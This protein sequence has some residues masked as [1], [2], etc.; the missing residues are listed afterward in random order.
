MRD[1]KRVIE[2]KEGRNW[3][4]HRV[5]TDEKEIYESL[6]HDLIAKKISACTWIK[7]IKRTQNYDG[8]ITITVLY[9]NNCRSLYTV[10]SDN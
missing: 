10:K 6:A 7:S 3:N 2:V 9:D 1:I 4:L 5:V 8:T